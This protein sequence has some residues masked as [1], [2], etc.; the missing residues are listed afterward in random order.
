M[1]RYP[2]TRTFA[3]DGKNY[4]NGVP[5]DIY[6]PFDRQA[7]QTLGRDNIIETACQLILNNE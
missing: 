3:L 5:P 4:E 2:V 1:Y 7:A 6:C